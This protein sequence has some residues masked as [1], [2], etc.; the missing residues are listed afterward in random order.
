MWNANLNLIRCSVSLFTSNIGW[1]RPK[2]RWMYEAYA[3]LYVISQYS[4]GVVDSL[5]SCVYTASEVCASERDEGI[6]I[7]TN[8]QATK[9]SRYCKVCRL[10]LTIVAHLIRWTSCER[11]R[12]T[13]RITKSKQTSI[14]NW[15]LC[16]FVI[17]TKLCVAR[18][19]HNNNN[20]KKISRK[21]V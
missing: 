18:H 16:V 11:E 19:E 21:N 1:I 2:N 8:S 9:T 6:W 15:P 7:L 4:F 17:E 10:C 3:W 12:S 5:Q 14:T 13:H 20:T